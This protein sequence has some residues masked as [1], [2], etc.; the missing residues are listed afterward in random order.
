MSNPPLGKL[1]AITS[2]LTL[3]GLSTTGQGVGAILVGIVIDNSEITWGTCEDIP[4]NDLPDFQSP[5]L[6]DEGIATIK[7]SVVPFLIGQKLTSFRPLATGIESLRETVTISKPKPRSEKRSQGISRRAI[8]TGFLSTSEPE[9]APALVEQITVERPIHPAI[10]HGL[11]Q[12]LSSAVAKVQGLTVV[13]VIAEEFDL[14]IPSTAVALQMPIQ[15][16]QSLLIHDQVSAL[17]YT[18]GG[19]DP[20]DTIGP[21]GQQIQ[22]FIRQLQE[23]LVES[24][25]H[26]QITIHLD[27]GGSLG[28]LY[29]ND[30]GKVLGAL[31]GLEQAASPC[32]IRVQDPLIMDDLD[33]QIKALSQL[34]DYLRM[35]RM[36]LQLV[37][38]A[39]IHTLDDVR[40]IARAEAAHMLHLVIPRLGTIQE[41]VLAIQA[42]QSNGVGILLEGTSSTFTAQIALATQP[43]ILTY[44]PDRPG[45][46]GVATFH[47]EMARMLTWLAKKESSLYRGRQEIQE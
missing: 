22:H 19:T 26:G 13:E 15:R 30:A 12:A 18:V 46:G 43:D 39:K 32:L 10:R 35:R 5:F 44:P 42:C 1:S 2:I 7:E 45:D 3:P 37:A 47:D 23:R 40:A 14:P 25:Q 38:G 36:S 34:R 41:L 11:S 6:V 24:G 21:D 17:A 9:A 4:A 33:A 28:R 16:G 31:Y 8:I 20:E 29:G 27:A